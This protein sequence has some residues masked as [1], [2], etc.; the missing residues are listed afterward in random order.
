MITYEKK[1]G[2]RK[3]KGI[4]DALENCTGMCCTDAYY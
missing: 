3:D 1:T 2:K 4:A